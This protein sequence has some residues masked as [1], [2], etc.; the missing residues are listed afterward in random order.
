[1]IKFILVFWLSTPSNYTVHDGFTS[2][3]NCE[4]KREFFTKILDK[5]NSNYNAEGRT[6]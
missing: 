6:V 2:L 4:E 3:S 5:V 1:M